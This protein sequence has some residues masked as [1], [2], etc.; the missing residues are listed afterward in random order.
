MVCESPSSTRRGSS[1]IKTV[2]VKK[3]AKKLVLTATLKKDNGK[4]LEGKQITFKLN[5]IIIKTVKTNKYGVA[6]V[7]IKPYILKSLKVGKKVTYQAIYAKTT[8]IKI[9]TV[10]R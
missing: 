6:Q 2:K 7:K 3:S 8:A 10:K 5:G 9:A 1:T 4:Y